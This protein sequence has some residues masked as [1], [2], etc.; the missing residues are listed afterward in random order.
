MPHLFQGLFLRAN[1]LETIQK[2]ETSCKAEGAQEGAEHA[3]G[4]IREHKQGA[5]LRAVPYGGQA[6]AMLLAVSRG[7]ISGARCPLWFQKNKLYP[8]PSIHPPSCSGKGEQAEETVGTRAQ[9][10]GHPRKAYG[11][12]SF[13]RK[14]VGFTISLTESE[15]RV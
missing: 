2:T 7:P 8:P 3:W 13:P 14:V 11:W 5:G 1:W 12:H 9:Q 4:R 10:T 15:N 6:D